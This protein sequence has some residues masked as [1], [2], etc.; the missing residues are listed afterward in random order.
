M[1]DFSTFVVTTSPHIV[2]RG[3]PSLLT[4][5]LPGCGRIRGTARAADTPW[6]SPGSFHPPR[7]RRPAGTFDSSSRRRAIVAATA[8][9]RR[10]RSEHAAVFGASGDENRWHGG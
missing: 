2:L 4:A 5:R 10:M 7:I 3:G 9:K 6:R 8:G 1:T